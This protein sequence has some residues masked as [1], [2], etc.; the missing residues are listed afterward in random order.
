MPGVTEKQ[1]AWAL[2]KHM[3][4]NGSG[5][6]PFDI[7]VGSGPNAALPHIRPSDRPV[8]EGETIVIDVGARW[9]GYCSDLTRTIWLGKPDKK[10]TQV[11]DTVLAAQQ[12]AMSTMTIGMHG[13]QADRLA[14]TV[15]EQAG[16]GD[17]FGH[18]LGHGVGLVPHE[19]PR[20]GAGSTDVLADGMVLTNE[21]GIYLTGWGGVR[22][23]DMVVLENGRPR[24][25][26]RARKMS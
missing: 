19:F 26:S 7:I 3:K 14:R 25:L 9:K 15:I 16:Y 21:P 12:T 13:E 1:I 10:L 18:S 11:Y 17:A 20:L 23:E 6:L 4:E 5:P 2:E 8:G 24:S 22:I